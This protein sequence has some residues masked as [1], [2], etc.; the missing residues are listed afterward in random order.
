MTHAG[1]PAPTD[2]IHAAL[3]AL[4]RPRKHSQW[5]DS[6]REANTNMYACSQ[7]VHAFLCA[8]YHMKRADWQ[9]NTPAPLQAW[10]ADELAN[11]PTYSIMNLDQ[12]MTET[13]ALE[14][15]SAADIA[16]CPWLPDVGLAVDSIEDNRTGFQDGLH[17][18][19][20]ATGGKDSRALNGSRAAQSLCRPCAWLARV[21][22]ACIS[23]PTPSSA[24]TTTPARPCAAVTGWT[25]PGI[26]CSK[27]TRSA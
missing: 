9:S 5:S 11:M 24:C 20:C 4:P 7:G 22:E 16:A 2:N 18:Y 3:A 17:W 26:G 8:S 6:T 19:R 13:V 25:G 15:P 27:S 21:T 14:I 12:G 23:A 1:A 10:S